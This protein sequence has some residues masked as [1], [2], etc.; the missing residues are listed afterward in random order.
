MSFT[1]RAGSYSQADANVYGVDSV[2]EV[3]ETLVV[4]TA[5]EAEQIRSAVVRHDRAAALRLLTE[6]LGKKIELMLRRRCK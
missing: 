6:V 4:L 3:L 1:G 2:L 5:Q